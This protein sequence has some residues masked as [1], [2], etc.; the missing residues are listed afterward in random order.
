MKVSAACGMIAARTGQSVHK[1]HRGSSPPRYIQRAEKRREKGSAEAPF[2][3]T[4]TTHDTHGYILCALYKEAEE[5][6][7]S[8]SIASSA[9][10]LQQQFITRTMPFFHACYYALLPRTQQI[11]LFRF[12]D[13]DMRPPPAPCAIN[14]HKRSGD[15]YLNLTSFKISQPA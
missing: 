9:T 13:G 3:T 10:R 8:S 4:L 7:K 11:G 12:H 6:K 14:R 5:E 15:V 2:F 1:I